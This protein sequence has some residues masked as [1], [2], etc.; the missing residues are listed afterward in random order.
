MLK[1]QS[2]SA[3]NS[4]PPSTTPPNTAMQRTT[5]CIPRI[6]SHDVEV[7]RN[8]PCHCGSGKKFKRCH[9]APVNDDDALIIDDAT[10]AKV[11]AQFDRMEDRCVK[12]TARS[13]CACKMHSYS[14]R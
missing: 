12:A 4:K 10:K 14:E 13:R 11:F 2:L 7:G 1:A 8:D 5:F 3:A 6:S 9:G